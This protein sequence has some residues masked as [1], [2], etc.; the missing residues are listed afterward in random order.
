MLKAIFD[1]VMDRRCRELTAQLRDWLPANGRVLDVGSGTG[2][3]AELLER[4]TAL[5]IVTADVTDMHVRGRAPVLITEGALPFDA[6]AFS[7]ALLVFMLHYP[8]DPVRLLRETARVTR[9]PLIVMQ[10]VYSGRAGYAWLRMR[11]FLWSWV[12]FHVSKVIGYVP[13]GAVFTMNARRF[14]TAPAL[15]RDVAAAGLR[16][17]ATRVRPVLPAGALAVSVWLL[18]ADARATS[19]DRA[20]A[21]GIATSHHRGSA[22]PDA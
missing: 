12:A 14:Y 7:A 18:E 9:G 20:T 5:E 16:V 2:H 19:P 21:F 15:L 17:R 4:E 13:R 6:G 1:A 22:G 3:L 11:E 8:D 10:T